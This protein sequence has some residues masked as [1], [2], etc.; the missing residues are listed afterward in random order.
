M[1]DGP[2]KAWGVLLKFSEIFVVKVCAVETKVEIDKAYVIPVFN[3]IASFRGVLFYVD[4]RKNFERLAPF[5][6]RR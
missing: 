6:D 1:S 3:E 2:T 5:V 4:G